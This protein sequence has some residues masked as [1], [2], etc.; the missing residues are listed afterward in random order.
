MAS[1]EILDMSASNP[2]KLLYLSLCFL[3]VAALCSIPRFGQRENEA[4][5]MVSDSDYFIDMARVFVGDEE[6]F[7]SDYVR[8]GAHHY[9]RPLLSLIAG[10]VG[11]Y[12]LK[13]GV[14]AAFSFVQIV[15]AAL[16]A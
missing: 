1:H 4:L 5:P 2:T 16:T 3:G 14:R 7:N 15:A 12:L 8:F 6:N 10:Y 13:G 11:K 9:N